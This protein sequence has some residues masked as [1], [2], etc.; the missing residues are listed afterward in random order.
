MAA[1]EG[2]TELLMPHVQAKVKVIEED[3]D[4]AVRIVDA[5]G[6]PRVDGKGNFLSITDLVSE[7]RQN[8]IYAPGFPKA[9]GSN[10]PGSTSVQRGASAKGK[11]DGTPEERTAYFQSKYADLK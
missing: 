8:P 11:I 9:Q 7:M 1:A 3:G 2:S 5:T 10:A 4:F 6:N